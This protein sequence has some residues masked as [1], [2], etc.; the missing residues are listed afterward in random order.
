MRVAPLIRLVIR[1]FEW[2]KLYVWPEV[3]IFVQQLRQRFPIWLK[4]FE[5]YRKHLQLPRITWLDT[6]PRLRSVLLKIREPLLE[7]SVLAV[8]VAL[9]V[10]FW[11]SVWL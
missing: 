9:F 11:R 3:E 10:L 7:I 1:I 2:L 6:R 8:S 5:N 4:K